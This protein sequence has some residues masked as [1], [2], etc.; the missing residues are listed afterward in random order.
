MLVDTQIVCVLEGR[1]KMK[2]KVCK[3][4]KKELPA[5]EK[6]FHK[7]KHR[8]DG[9]RSDCRECRHIKRVEYYKKHKQEAQEYN[10]VYYA[11][12]NPMTRSI[13]R[14]KLNSKL[15]LEC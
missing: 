12:N 2:T 4:C 15:Y 6:Y 13:K 9:L 1:G 5:T 7:E 3:T 8:K 11:L 14:N 10:K